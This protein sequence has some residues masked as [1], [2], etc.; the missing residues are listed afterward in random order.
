MLDMYF[1]LD[2]SSFLRNDDFNL[3]AE[4]LRSVSKAV[5]GRLNRSVISMAIF[6]FALLTLLL[7]LPVSY[8]FTVDIIL[9]VF[10]KGDDEPPFLELYGTRF[11]PW[12]Y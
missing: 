12:S 3:L 8:F 4:V 11:W 2:E 7:D 9:R 6:G 1:S 5:D 10:F